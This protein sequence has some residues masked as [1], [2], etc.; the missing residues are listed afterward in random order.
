ME[1]VWSGR[2]LT[3]VLSTCD[4]RGMVPLAHHGIPASD[5]VC[6]G[7]SIWDPTPLSFSISV[8]DEPSQVTRCIN[9]GVLLHFI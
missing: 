2:M 4:G 6:E 9:S 1:G 7:R 8:M 3:G 5:P